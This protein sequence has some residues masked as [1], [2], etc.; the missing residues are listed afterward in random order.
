M[1]IQRLFHKANKFLNQ[2]R[3][4]T[5]PPFQETDNG[6][7]GMTDFFL[8]DSESVFEFRLNENPRFMERQSSETYSSRLL[9]EEPDNDVPHHFSL[10]SFLLGEA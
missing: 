2:P 7:Y 3:E 4:S 8:S 5:Q 6:G 1:N 9:D 10:T